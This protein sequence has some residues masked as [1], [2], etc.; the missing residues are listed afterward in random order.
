MKFVKLPSN[1]FLVSGFIIFA[2]SLFVSN[3]T[4]DYYFSDTYSVVDYKWL[5]SGIALIFLLF[6]VIYK[7]TSPLLLSKVLTWMHVIITLCMIAFILL[8]P[9]ITKVS[10][11]SGFERMDNFKTMQ[12]ASKAIPF[13]I[14]T[15]FLFIINLVSGAVKKSF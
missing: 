4:I 11:Q 6:W 7:L 5:L 15:Q 12:D 3:R 9:V 10:G 14:L 8:Y 13:L 1:M 2:I